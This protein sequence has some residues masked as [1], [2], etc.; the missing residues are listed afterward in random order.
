MMENKD[1][2]TRDS[3][4]KVT[5]LLASIEEKKASIFSS[6]KNMEPSD[7]K[8]QIGRRLVYILSLCSSFSSKFSVLLDLLLKELGQEKVNIAHAIKEDGVDRVWLLVQDLRVRR[9]K[10][11]VSVL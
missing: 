4:L 2:Q 7:V 3:F 10:Y 6:Y 5:S 1:L 11:A 9:S 8:S